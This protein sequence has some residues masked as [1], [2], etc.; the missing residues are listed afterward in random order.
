MMSD[1]ISTTFYTGKDYIRDVNY[2]WRIQIII[3]L[4]LIGILFGLLCSIFMFW[5]VKLRAHVGDRLKIVRST[6]NLAWI[7]SRNR[8]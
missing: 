5:S 4:C 2:P 3:F 8:V 7:V 6:N 1:Y